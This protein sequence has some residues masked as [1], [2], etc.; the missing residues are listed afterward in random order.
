MKN[1]RNLRIKNVI[2]TYT[3]DSG[4][5]PP[6]VK[7]GDKFQIIHDKYIVRKVESHPRYLDGGRNPYEVKLT[8]QPINNYC[9]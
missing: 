5:L 6:S 1:L 8:T 3:E 7:I 2:F 9:G 4:K